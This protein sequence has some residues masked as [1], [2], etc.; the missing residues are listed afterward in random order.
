MGSRIHVIIRITHGC[1]CFSRSPTAVGRESRTGS[2][3]AC[4]RGRSPQALATGGES[5]RRSGRKLMQSLKGHRRLTNKSDGWRAKSWSPSEPAHSRSQLEAPL[6]GPSGVLCTS[7]CRRERQMLPAK[8][9]ALAG[10]GLPSEKGIA[11]PRF[12]T[13]KMISMS[14]PPLSSLP[15]RHMMARRASVQSD[16]DISS[17][18][19]VLGSS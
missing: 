16:E 2:R 6:K 15:R 9:V 7:G 18:T 12:R 10:C 13:G 19:L 1:Q 5:H 4:S 8:K 14:L 3:R 11:P 17:V